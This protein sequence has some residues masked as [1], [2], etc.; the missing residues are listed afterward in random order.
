VPAAQTLG[1]LPA[2]ALTSIRP[3]VMIESVAIR[4][5]G[6]F[7]VARKVAPIV[8]FVAAITQ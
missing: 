2:P 4:T 7:P 5:S 8:M 6:F 3:V 1:L